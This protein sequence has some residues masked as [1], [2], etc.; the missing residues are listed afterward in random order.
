MVFLEISHF[1]ILII[2][3]VVY[4]ESRNCILY[5]FYV[6]YIFKSHAKYI[7]CCRRNQSFVE[8]NYISLE[9]EFKVKI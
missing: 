2:Y 9:N 4:T 3:T 6:V 7:I 5:N 8:D 1:N